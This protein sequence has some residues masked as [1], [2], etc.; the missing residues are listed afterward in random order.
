MLLL[1]VCVCVC[2]CVY[3]FIEFITILLL[4]FALTFWSWGM[5]G[6]GSLTTDWTHIPCIGRQRFYHWTASE[7][8]NSVFL[9]STSTL[10]HTVFVFL[11][12]TYCKW[13][14]SCLHVSS[15]SLHYSLDHHSNRYLK[16]MEAYYKHWSIHLAFS[17]WQ[18]I[19][20]IASDQCT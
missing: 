8:P 15:Y 10:S 11:C 1:C 19:L 14:I 20:E 5:W 7:V 17:C 13:M 3:V 2:V 12:L 4:F 9:D 18:Y 16:Q 6:L